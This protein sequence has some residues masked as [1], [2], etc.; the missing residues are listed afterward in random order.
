[1]ELTAKIASNPFKTEK[2]P[3]KAEK[4]HDRLPA[5]HGADRHR[6]L[7]F[8]LFCI[9]DGGDRTRGKEKLSGHPA[10][11]QH[12]HYFQPGLY[13]LCSHYLDG[14][15]P[16]D[17]IRPV[18]HAVL[19]HHDRLHLF[20]NHRIQKQSRKEDQKSAVTLRACRYYRL[21]KRY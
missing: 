18:Q 8:A 16:A 21:E 12:Q 14:P 5:G 7:H 19:V 3:Y 15:G 2:T 11:E 9:L 13:R 6:G 10:L 4:T 1:M 17:D 20:Q